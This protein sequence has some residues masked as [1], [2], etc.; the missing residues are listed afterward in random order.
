MLSS[1]PVT[2]QRFALVFLEGY[3]SGKCSGNSCEIQA[4]FVNA[5]ITTGAFAGAYEPTS[6]IHFVKLTE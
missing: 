6:L 4:R 2:I 5:D 1:S 3:Q